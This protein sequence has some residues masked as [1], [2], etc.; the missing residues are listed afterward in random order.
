MR[1]GCHFEPEPISA[2]PPAPDLTMRTA[3]R[4]LESMTTPPA[5]WVCPKNECP[6][7]RIATLSPWRFANC[8][9]FAMSCAS[10]GRSMAEHHRHRGRCGLGRDCRRGV[11][12]RDHCYPAA[13]QFAC[14]VGQSIVLVLSPAILDRPGLALDIAAFPQAAQECCQKVSPADRRGAAQQPDD[15]HRLLR[16]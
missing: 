1:T 7:P 4:L 15:R 2:V 5:T 9:S 12:R 8:T 6:W 11:D 14:E 16:P 10:L 3:F 13:R